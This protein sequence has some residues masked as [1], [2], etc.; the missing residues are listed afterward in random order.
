[1]KKARTKYWEMTAA[2]LADATREFDKPFA[3]SKARPMNA[4]ERERENR[5]RAKLGR[6]KLGKGARAI[7]V[8]IEQGLLSRADAYAKHLG[9]SRAKLIA[10]G[11]EQVMPRKAG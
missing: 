1:M 11:L 9:L 10:R 5:F 4:A 3:A 2:Q 6:P 8:T 7:S